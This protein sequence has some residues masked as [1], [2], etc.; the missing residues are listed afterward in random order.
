ML[1]DVR[2]NRV[3]C[4]ER[5]GLLRYVREVDQ[6]V[7]ADLSIGDLDPGRRE[8][9]KEEYGQNA[10]SEVLFENREIIRECDTYNDILDMSEAIWEQVQNKNQEK[11]NQDK[12]ECGGKEKR[13]EYGWATGACED[14]G[15]DKSPKPENMK[16]MVK[17]IVMDGVDKSSTKDEDKGTALFGHDEATGN[18]HKFHPKK[19][20]NDNMYGK[21]VV[22]KKQ[23]SFFHGMTQDITPWPIGRRLLRHLQKQQHY[24]RP[25]KSGKLD[26]LNPVKMENN[27]RWYKR[28]NTKSKK[29]H[30]YFICDC[31]GSMGHGSQLWQKTIVTTFTKVLKK[32]NIKYTILAHTGE[33]SGWRSNAGHGKGE[34]FYAE[35]KD[36]DVPHM[37]GIAQNFD[38][39]MVGVFL[40]DY[41]DK[42]ENSIVFY[43]SDANLPAANGAFEGPELKKNLKIAKQKGIPIMAIGLGTASVSKF[44]EKWFV[45][46]DEEDFGGAIKAIGREIKKSVRN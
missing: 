10:L 28:K 43:I 15:K 2:V 45:V 18:K 25:A 23:P 38:G 14:C 34:L 46:K 24:Y 8:L 35:L 29:P 4:F 9:S 21:N 3:M 27:K 12:C 1:E 11:S 7:L 16:D 32:A 17:D 33:T 40:R 30:F 26:K 13:D 22:V 39:S 41:A 6:K 44:F 5:G 37:N 31:S 42:K 19:V 36:S 20:L